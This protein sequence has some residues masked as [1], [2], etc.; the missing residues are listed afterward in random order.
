MLTSRRGGGTLALFVAGSLL[1]VTPASGQTELVGRGPGVF[2]GTRPETAPREELVIAASVAGAYDSDAPPELFQ[3]VDPSEHIFSGRSALLLGGAD[4]RRSG[5][6][7]VLA[8]AQTSLRYA[9]DDS[10]LRVLNHDAGL[11]LSTD[12]PQRFTLSVE[13]RAAYSPSLF[14][15]FPADAAAAGELP[16]LTPEYAV[17]DAGGYSYSGQVGLAR[18]VGRRNLFSGAAELQYADYRL[19]TVNR[20]DLATHGASAAYSR[21]VRRN[22]TLRVGYRY[23]TGEFGFSNFGTTTEHGVD[24]GFSHLKPLSRTRR[25]ELTFSLGSSTVGVPRA[26]EAADVIGR[27]Y[28]ASGSA[29]AR[30]E[31]AR[32]WQVRGSVQRGVEYV[33]EFTEPV[34]ADG[35]TTSLEGLITRRLDLVMSAGYSR[36]ASALIAD[37][38]ELDTYT[39]TVRLRYALA[40]SYALYVQAFHYRY[41]SSGEAARLPDARRLIERTGVRAGLTFWVPVLQRR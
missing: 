37:S 3:L 36:G 18:P 14:G 19:E 29:A 9:P 22:S 7:Q 35:F 23:R 34:F 13:Q 8:G 12:L 30:Y 4:Y 21:D 26:A 25:A 38:F 40:R 32:T 24:I 20:R 39:G 5:V 17:A 2:G 1:G 31:F 15:L 33:P 6:V 11:S 27:R 41:E 16:A 10:G 28:L